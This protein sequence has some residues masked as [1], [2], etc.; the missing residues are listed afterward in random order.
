MNSMCDHRIKQ[1]NKESLI[2]LAVY[3]VYFLWWYLSGYGIGDTDPDTYSY[4]FGFP[5]WFF[6]SCILGYPLITVIL[7]LVVRLFF[8]EI[9]LDADVRNTSSMKG[10]D[11]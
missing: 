7:W 10:E 11:N 3:A 2:S 5:S 6:Y 4:I 9:P 8:K 1:A